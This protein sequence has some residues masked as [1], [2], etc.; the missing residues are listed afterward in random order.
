MSEDNEPSISPASLLD[1]FAS[2]FK[3]LEEEIVDKKRRAP[4]MSPEELYFLSQNYVDNYEIFHGTVKGASREASIVAKSLLLNNIANGLEVLGYPKRTT[5]QI[6]Q[7]IRDNLKKSREFFTQMKKGGKKLNIPP[8]IKLLLDRPDIKA[9]LIGG[10]KASTEINNSNKDENSNRTNDKAEI[11]SQKKKR[12][13]EDDEPTTSESSKRPSMDSFADS[14][15]MTENDSPMA[16]DQITSDFICSFLS[17]AS[18]SLSKDDD[19]EKS[20]VNH[21]E[22][23]KEEESLNSQLIQMRIENEKRRQELLDAQIQ[24]EKARLDCALLE[25]QYWKKK[26]K[27][28]LID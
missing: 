22:N 11:K 2:I 28:A 24:L 5:T 8:H 20:C 19:V 27:L 12:A 17:N 1:S 15:A 25:A 21:E 9:R 4:V 13:R 7:R 18:S 26:T 6:E 10:S 23:V 16:N 14:P 3:P